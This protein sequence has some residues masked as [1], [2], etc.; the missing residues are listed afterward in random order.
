[1]IHEGLPIGVQVVAGR[2]KEERC[3][4]VGEIIERHSSVKTP[5][6]PVQTTVTPSQTSLV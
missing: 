5:I 1:M 2:F 6:D 3:F 4:A